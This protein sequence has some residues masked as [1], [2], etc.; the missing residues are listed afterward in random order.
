MYRDNQF[1]NTRAGYSETTGTP[2]DP[3]LLAYWKF[4]GNSIDEVG[5]YTATWQTGSEQYTAGIGQ[6]AKMSPSNQYALANVPAAT[7]GDTAS[8]T[9]TVWFYANNVADSAT[10]ITR[11]KNSGSGYNILLTI[12]P[13]SNFIRVRIFESSVPLVYYGTQVAPSGDMTQKWTFLAITWDESTDTGIVYQGYDGAALVTTNLT[14]TGSWTGPRRMDADHMRIGWLCTNESWI[15]DFR[16]YGVLK[17][18]AGI[19]AIYD[20]G[21]TALGL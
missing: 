10:T 6:A 9:W 7:M 19:G 5:P 8:F 12:Q 18:A 1:G 11:I 13:V 17:D 3:D 16:Y 2:I 15:D 21:K 14:E 4:D 20:E